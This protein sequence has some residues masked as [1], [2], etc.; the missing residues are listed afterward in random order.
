[1]RVRA[2]LTF[3]LLG[4]TV[5]AIAAAALFTS[6]GVERHLH[7]RIVRELR[8]A[9][10][11]VE[12]LL[13]GAAPSAAS[14]DLLRAH[15]RA[16]RTRVTIV[17]HDGGV[18]FDS[19]V[20]EEGLARL[21]NH[22][23]RPEIAEALRGRIG[24]STRHSVTLD[25]DLLY[26]AR[27]ILP[28]AAVP[29]L[30]GEAAAVRVSI[31]LTEVQAATAELRA[32]VAVVSLLVLAAVIFTVALLSRRLTEPL[33]EMADVAGR[34]RSGELDRRITVRSADE[35]GRL[36]ESLNAM[37]D[38]LNRDIVR[39]RK[40]ERVRTEFLANV[41]HELRTPIFA[42][43]GMIETL[44]GGAVDDP[45][46]NRDFLRRALDNTRN[47]NALLS[48]LIEISRIESGDMKMSFR[49]FDAGELLKTVATEMAPIAAPRSVRLV[50][51]APPEG[52]QVYG[53]RERLK[54][55]LT[56][57]VENA[58]KYNRP[59]G[60]VRLEAGEA[61]AGLRFAVRDDG[62]GIAPEHRERIFERFYRVDKERS[63]ETGGTGLGLAIVKHIVEAHGSRVVVESEPGNGSTF[64]FVL[65]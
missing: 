50:T 43:Q 1:M 44:L 51:A 52:R 63:R 6:L 7:A 8:A 27:P 19:D 29:G 38:E 23:D 14:A 56:N 13:R 40:L 16:G 4:I 41:S 34:I 57:L 22:G 55:V 9:A 21:E 32:A 2:K 47:L 15:A 49:Y 3:V 20:S 64:S 26:V 60:T 48:D 46:V 25:Q 36:G 5:P 53:D 31:P 24:T 45:E 17:T 11:Q 37:I 28:A 12:I 61:E 58:I 59:E 39:L 10:E 65:R 42:I 18:I 54:Q 33:T 62:V 35:I 30:A